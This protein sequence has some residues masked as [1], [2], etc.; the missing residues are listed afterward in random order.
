MMCQARAKVGSW[1]ACMLSDSAAE[2]N[3][4]EVCS[5]FT[6]HHIDHEW[7]NAEQQFQDGASETIVNMLC[8]AVRVQLLMSCMAPEFWGLAMMNAVHMYNCL[9][10]SAIDW[11]VPHFAQTGCMQDVLWFRAFGCVLVFFRALTSL[12]MEN[13]PPAARL[14]C[15]WALV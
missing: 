6:E 9:P 12:S 14:G 8:R 1:P 15:T 10:H 7:S 5:L 4:P 3:S 11:Q 2:Y 13:L